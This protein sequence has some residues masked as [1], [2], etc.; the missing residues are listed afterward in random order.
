MDLTLFV[1]LQVMLQPSLS[2]LFT[3]EAGQTT[4]KSEFG[5]NVVMGCRFSLK[6]ARPNSDLKVTWHWTTDAP[7]QEVIRIDNGAEHSASQKYQGRVRLLTDELKDGWAKL[8]MSDLRINDSGTYQCVVQTAEGTDYKTITLSVGA[9]YKPV[10]KRIETTPNGDMVLLICQSEGYPKTSV[11]WSDGHMQRHS[12]NTTTVTT[13]D[14][15]FKITS[16][17]QVSSSEKNNYTCNFTSDGNFATFHIP[18]ET[19]AYREESGAL[20]IA[21]SIGIIL[22]V[23]TVGVLIYRRQKGASAATTMNSLLD[24]LDRSTS[25]AS[26]LQTDQKNGGE[27]TVFVGGCTEEDLGSCLKEYYSKFSLSTETRQ[28]CESFS[29]EE[30]PRRL[31][32]NEGQSV[33]LLDLIPEAGEVL[34]LEGP[35]GSGKTTVAQI[36]LSSWTEGPRLAPSNFPDL[37]DLGHLICVD[38]SMAKSDLFQETATQLSL[39]E[40][41]STQ[42]LRTVLTSSGRSLLLLDGYREGNSVFDESLNR[43]LSERGQCSLLITACSGHCPTL[44]E[45][46]GTDRVLKLQMPSVRY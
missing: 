13:P 11:G 42:E 10:N 9:T 43:F 26:Y 31:T 39:S 24:D 20:I 1:F 5:G 14:Q 2:V 46:L 33:S 8:Q 29:V 12:P 23:I 21:L 38:C 17:I 45:T 16:Q 40:K 37:S 3:V 32:N 6:P 44:T 41:I 19:V 27:G 35:T 15:L 30:L 28:H 7:Y 25:A 4:Y 36:L 22:T 18:D 34:I